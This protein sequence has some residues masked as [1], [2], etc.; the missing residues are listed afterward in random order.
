MKH[1]THW[2][3]GKPSRT[4]TADARAR[5]STRRPARS[6]GTSTSPRPPTSTRPWP[7]PRR[8]S[9]PGATRRWPSGRRCCSRFR[10]LMLRP[11]RRAGRA[12]HA[13]STARCSP[14]RRRGRRAAS[15]SWSSPA[16]SR[17]CSRAASPRTS[18]PGSTPTRSA[19]RSGVVAG[20]TPFNFPA[21]VPMWMF[22]IAIACGNTFVLKPS[23]KDPSASMLH[24]AE[25]WQEAGLPDGVFNVVHG[26]KVAR[27]RR[28]STTP[29]CEAVSLRRLDAH[30]Q[31]RLR[32]RHRARQ[33]GAGARRRQ[34][35]HGRAAR[36]RPRP[37]RRRG[38]VGAG[39]GSAGERCMA[40]SVVRGGRPGRR[41][42]GRTR[43]SSASPSW[44]SARAT[45]PPPRWAR[46]SPRRTATRSPSYLDGGVAEGA[47]L[48]VDGRERAPATAARTG[49]WLGPDRCST[50]SRPDMRVL[51]GRDLRP[52]PVGRAR[53][54]PTRRA[55]ELINGNPYGN[56]TA[57]FTNDGGAARRFQNEVEVGMIGINVPIPVPMA[58]YSLRRLEGVAV[59]RH[60][61]ARRRGRALLHPRQGRHRRAGSTRR[62]AA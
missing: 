53:R 1:V 43:S 18:R 28:C 9:P 26:D 62:T 4:A 13:P 17:T 40:I 31:V 57:I 39:F 25:L 34:E 2:I 12:H 56:G 3:D 30:R 22:P 24:G 35:P 47:T 48:V 8:P 41:R 6:A 15:R 55:L 36:R 19:S 52:G 61:R 33:A 14:T 23:E 11:P 37:G 20:I 50:T 27:R 46:W 59:R 49:F 29:T 5:S 42:A 16:A 32:D 10:E 7:P 58:Y 51:H 45:T 54:R 60:P 21:M 44:R 38:R